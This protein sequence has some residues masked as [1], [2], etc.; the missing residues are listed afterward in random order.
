MSNS[1]TY[2][3]STASVDAVSQTITL[4]HDDVQ[5]GL[6][7][8]FRDVIALLP[9]TL[10][11]GVS[12][13]KGYTL[14]YVGKSEVGSNGS[15][16][17]EKSSITKSVK[18]LDPPAVLLD[19]F[20]ISCLPE[21]LSFPSGEN[22]QCDLHVVVSVKS[23]ICEAEVFFEGVVQVAFHAL[24]L[25]EHRYQLH[26]TSSEQSIKEFITNVLGPRAK[27]GITQ[28]A[29][30]LSGDG[31]IVDIIN[32]LQSFRS[33]NFVQPTIGLL[34][35]GTGNALANSAGLNRDSTRGLRGFLRGHPQNLPTFAATF[36]LD[37]RHMIDE[38]RRTESLSTKENPRGIVYGAVVC[39]WALH[40]SLVADSDTTEYRKFGPQRFQM[41]AKELLDPSDGSKPHIYSGRVTLFKKNGNGQEYTEHLDRTKH[42]YLLATLVSNLEE[43]L[44]ISPR[45]KPLDGQLRLVH[46]GAL[47]SEEI[48]RILGLAFQG[49]KHVF[50]ASVGYDSI[51]GMRI[52]LDEEDSHWRRICID[53]KIVQ[54]DMGGWVEVRKEPFGVVKLVVEDHS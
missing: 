2:R 1:V 29:L 31:G 3:A 30:L 46:F 10:V 19:N 21:H 4:H 38:G 40:A 12:Q 11:P 18:V 35:L 37:S 45:S 8:Q 14:L 43:Q 6:T 47:S 49:G 34:A 52:D 42:M 51:E 32:V 20:L 28:S 48:M 54:V 9:P 36:S 33:T 24:G 17:E 39:S 41:A 22:E 15:M 50:E 23:G 26:K 27:S 5:H 25:L 13:E 53:G 16:E 7:I 44:S